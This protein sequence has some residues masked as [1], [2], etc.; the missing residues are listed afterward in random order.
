MA[1]VMEEGFEALLEEQK[2]TNELLAAARGDK[3]ALKEKEQKK[4][5][6]AKK[7]RSLLTKIAGG[8]T[9]MFGSMKD[10]AGKKFGGGG[11]KLLGILKAALVTGAL[12]AI[13]AFLNSEYWTKTKKWI[14]EVGAPMLKDLWEKIIKPLGIWLKDKFIPFFE[15]LGSFIKDPSWDKFKTL[16]TENKEAVGLLAAALAVKTLGIVTITTGIAAAGT[17]IASKWGIPAVKA[18]LSSTTVVA[19]L[20][21]VGIVTSLALAVKSGF[22]GVSINGVFWYAG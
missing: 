10:F 15:D 6:G 18:A 12:V 1:D 21:V 8:V 22:E 2:K 16:I 13:V 19:A 11:K 20:S 5:T 17:A 9:G 7:E 3:S 4:T 14:K